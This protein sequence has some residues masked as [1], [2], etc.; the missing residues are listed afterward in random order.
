MTYRYVS[1]SEAES[2]F[3]EFINDTNDMIEILG[4]SFE[5]AHALEVLDATAWQEMFNNWAD[6][7]GIT[8]DE[9]EADDDSDDDDELD[10]ELD[11]WVRGY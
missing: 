4:M 2:M 8:T 11:D 5:P 3:N 10:D 6:S 1:Q 7:E 9:D